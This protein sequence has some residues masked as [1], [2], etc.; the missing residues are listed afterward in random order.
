MQKYR[1]FSYDKIEGRK[2]NLVYPSGFK[3]VIQADDEDQVKAMIDKIEAH[4]KGE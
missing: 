1:G 4:F 3:T 2:W